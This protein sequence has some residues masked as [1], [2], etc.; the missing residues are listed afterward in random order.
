MLIVEADKPAV[1]PASAIAIDVKA[2]QRT[3]EHN[4]GRARR[5]NARRRHCAD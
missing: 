4:L 3:I 1:K 2:M 5:A